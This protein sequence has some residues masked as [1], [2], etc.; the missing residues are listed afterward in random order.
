MSYFT[1]PSGKA[2]LSA[3]QTIYYDNGAQMGIA[4]KSRR[5]KMGDGYQSITH[6]SPPKKTLA[7][8]FSNRPPEEINLIERYF[9]ELAGAPLDGLTIL[10]AAV[11][12]KVV[13]F[14]KNYNNGGVYSLSAEIK[15][16]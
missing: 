6:L 16:D 1:I 10:G 5:M 9:I 7:V 2:G 11:S 8:S 3:S 12:A 15:E 13:A 14:N 4:R